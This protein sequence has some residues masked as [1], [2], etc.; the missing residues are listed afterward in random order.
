M[1]EYKMTEF[2]RWCEENKLTARNI[3]EKTGI[4][5][6][7]VYSYMEGRRHPSRKMMKLLV[8]AYSIDPNKVFPL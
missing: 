3:S 4:S 5:Q 1:A 6:Q 7:T 2:K 8:E